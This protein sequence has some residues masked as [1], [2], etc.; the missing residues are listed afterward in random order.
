MVLDVLQEK[1]LPLIEA[2][3][4]QF[5]SNLDFGVS[6]EM[7]QM[8]TYHLGWV[9]KQGDSGSRGKRIR[10]FLTLLCAGA[11]NTDVIKALPG[12]VS[13]ELLHNFTL[14]HDDIEDD[15]LLRHGRPTLWKQWGTAQAINAGDALFSIAQLSM[16]SLSKTCD[17][18][19]ALTAAKHLNQI[20]LQ[21]TRGQY[22]DISFESTKTI[23]TATY[24]EMI[25]GK[26][27]ALIALSTALGSLIANQ[28]QSIQNE[29]SEFGKSLGL[30]FQIQDDYLGVW[31]DP[32]VTGKSAASDLLNRKKTLPVLFGLTECAEFRQL[33]AQDTLSPADVERMSI[34]LETCGAQ[35]FVRSK[36]EHF[37]TQAYQILENVFPVRNNYATA[38]FELTEKLLNRQA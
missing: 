37:T 23:A 35:E 34:L 19:I 1:L 4:K 17:K 38:L 29:L 2:E 11:F 9:I 16:L 3:L 7:K 28:N 30:A 5:I 36:A 27:A 18:S 10:P 26:T 6:E 32:E 21:L 24:L 20:C 25:E 22:L 33:W 13:L 14:I 31:G 12:A 8:I 15:S